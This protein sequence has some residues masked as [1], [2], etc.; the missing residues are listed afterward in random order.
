[1]GS[2]HRVPLGFLPLLHPSGHGVP[3]RSMPGSQV[4]PAPGSMPGAFTCYF[5][6]REHNLNPEA[7]GLHRDFP[8]GASQS[9][10]M[11]SFSI[12]GDHRMFRVPRPKLL[13]CS[14][15]RPQGPLGLWALL[16]CLMRGSHSRCGTW[17]TWGLR[18]QS[19]LLLRGRRWC[20]DDVHAH[21]VRPRGLA[22]G[23]PLTPPPLLGTPPSPEQGVQ[24]PPSL[25]SPCGRV[26]IWFRLRRWRW[27]HM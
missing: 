17:G 16:C 10:P 24:A 2:G 9:Y 20:D 27:G 4:L 11:A 18:D 23:K 13:S 5:C 3:S 12:S 8:T 22:C 1:M 25:S 6:R 26:G 19:C 15:C 14:P 7:G 21:V